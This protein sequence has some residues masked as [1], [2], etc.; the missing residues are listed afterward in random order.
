MLKATGSFPLTVR[1]LYVSRAVGAVVPIPT[2]PATNNEVGPA[3]STKKAVLFLSTN[4]S[5]VTSPTIV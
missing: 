5:A 1:R 3:G 2:L 4:L